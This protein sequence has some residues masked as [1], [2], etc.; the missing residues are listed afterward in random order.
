M[1]AF[2]DRSWTATTARCPSKTELGSVEG[3]GGAAERQSTTN[4]LGAG[5]V[6]GHFGDRY[7]ATTGPLH[8][9][10]QL[11]D[12]DGNRPLWRPVECRQATRD[13]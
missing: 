4:W 1:G 7:G 5:I 3:R 8:N 6:K 13:R 2:G 12:R 9:K 10:G 11:W